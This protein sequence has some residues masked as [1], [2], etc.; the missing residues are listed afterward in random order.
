MILSS[1]M[2]FSQDA[3]QIH[4]LDSAKALY[5][6]GKF[7]ESAS[8]YQS[9]ADSGV[10]SSTLYYNLGNC[11]FK[12]GD[13]A[14]AILYYEKALKVT[15]RNEDV[16]HNLSVVNGTLIDKFEKLPSFSV[17]PL[18]TSINSLVSYNV[19]GVLSLI[20]LLIAGFI[21]YRMKQKGSKFTFS[22]S[23]L[24]LVVAL[25]SYSWGAVQKSQVLTVTSGVVSINGL[26]VRSEPNNDAT[27]LF[28]LN[29]G[30]K[31]EFK[32]GSDKWLNIKTQ[33]GNQGWVQKDQLLEI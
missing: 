9:F 28:E 15:P 8:I 6:E 2:L 22:N 14:H 12:I 33:D 13:K 21:F 24:I 17:R 25:V 1:G 18:F 10:V 27:L 3:Q 5:D 29:E 23:W 32:G 7:Y 4:L 30:S 31:V 20:S 11:K 16:I 26:E 19:L